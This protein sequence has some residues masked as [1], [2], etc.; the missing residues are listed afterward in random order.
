MAGALTLFIIFVLIY[1]VI[2]DI[3]TVL[4]RLTG[5]TEENARFQVISLL[6]NSGFTT[7]ESEAIVSSKVRRRIARATMMFGYAFTVTIVATMVNFFTTISKDELSTLIKTI[8]LLIFIVVLFYA[9]RTSTMIKTKFD[10]RIERIGNILMFGSKSNPVVIVEDY[11]DM[12]VAQIYLR[13]VPDILKDTKL[14]QSTIRTE[15]DIMILM[16]KNP[17]G[18]AKQ[19]NPDTIVKKND[20][21]MVLGKRNVIREIFEKIE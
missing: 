2:S 3:I 17:Y 16:V 9:L 6:T 8:P 12:V 13:I 19:A 10:K 4:F 18:D 15:H 5:L 1:I 20:I 21:I 7:R 14:S 11:D